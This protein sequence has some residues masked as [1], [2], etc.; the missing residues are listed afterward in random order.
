MICKRAQSRF[1]ERA[2]ATVPVAKYALHQLLCGLPVSSGCGSEAREG[3]DLGILQTFSF[4]LR[5]A[6]ARAADLASS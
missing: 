4:S 2:S 6:P 3:C 1:L 5:H